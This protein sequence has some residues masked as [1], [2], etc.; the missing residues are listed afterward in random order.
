MIISLSLSNA[1]QHFKCNIYNVDRDSLC[2]LHTPLSMSFQMTQRLATLWSWLWPYI[3]IAFW[4]L[5][6]AEGKVVL[7][8]F[9]QIYLVFELTLSFYTPV[10]RRDVLWYGD[11]RP[12]GSPSV[13][14]TLRPSDSP[15]DMLWRALTYWAEI[16]H[17]T[18]FYCTTDQVRVSSIFVNFYRSKIPFG[19]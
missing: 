7:F 6:V 10:F 18:L 4:D 15:P 1:V 17:T 19:M 2:W 14:P 9:L 13:R 11:V 16:L 5:A 8:C 12:S 3:K